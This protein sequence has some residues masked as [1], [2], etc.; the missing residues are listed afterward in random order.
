[1]F[2]LIKHY[3]CILVILFSGALG[4]VSVFAKLP[5]A[6]SVSEQNQPQISTVNINTATAEELATRLKGIGLNKAQRIVA[7]RE[8]YGPFI[9]IEQLKEVSGIGQSILD[10]NSA[11][12]RL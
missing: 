10:K 11:I 9:E 6:I 7:Y 2:T 1:M 5:S 12:L 8:K 4:S 3:S